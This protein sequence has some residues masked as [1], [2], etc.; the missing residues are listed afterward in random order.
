MAISYGVMFDKPDPLW[1]HLV[2]E[3]NPTALVAETTVLQIGALFD[4]LA[5]L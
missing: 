3:L 1:R 4:R 2:F 5:S